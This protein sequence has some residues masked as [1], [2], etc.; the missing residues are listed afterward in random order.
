MRGHIITG[1][2]DWRRYGSSAASATRTATSSTVVS[3]STVPRASVIRLV[4]VETTVE[5][6]RLVEQFLKHP[7]LR[8]RTLAP[9]S[10]TAAARRVTDTKLGDP[11]QEG[12]AYNTSAIES[13][14]GSEFAIYSVCFLCSV[15][16]PFLHKCLSKKLNISVD[17]P[18]LK[19]ELL[20]SQ[21]QPSSAKV[22]KE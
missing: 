20:S 4:L 6:G 2:S 5:P 14:S 21:L 3:P 7:F 11:S 13:P 9:G 15:P 18:H 19:G 1:I 12:T 10:L 16:R 8:K 17:E 22:K